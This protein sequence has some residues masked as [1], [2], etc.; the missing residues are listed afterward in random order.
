MNKKADDIRSDEEILAVAKRAEANR[1]R[2]AYR[3]LTN[4][5]R[6]ALEAAMDDIVDEIE[7]IL[8]DQWVGVY[9]EATKK[10][11]ELVQEYMEG[12]CQVRREVPLP[13]LLPLLG[14]V[15]LCGSRSRQR[16][17]R[18]RE[19]VVGGTQ[20]V[21]LAAGGERTSG[22][23]ERPTPAHN[24]RCASGGP[25]ATNKYLM[26]DAWAGPWAAGEEP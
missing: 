14:G 25:K 23:C 16:R 5:E 24:P 7:D 3:A 18:T 20:R 10:A 26:I 17:R 4:E 2:E 21:I 8:V 6:G 1:Q 11:A 13:G 9:G 12:C 22:S 19:A 15:G